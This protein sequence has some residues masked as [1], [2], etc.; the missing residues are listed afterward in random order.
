PVPAVEARQLARHLRAVGA[1]ER[2]LPGGHERARDHTADGEAADV[3]VVAQVVRLEA[4]GRVRIVRRAGEGGRDDLEERPQV[5]PLDREIAR[6]RPGTRV[7][8]DDREVELR[9]A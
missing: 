2:V 4:Y 1:A 8:V 7:R 5:L 9:L 6:R 3:V